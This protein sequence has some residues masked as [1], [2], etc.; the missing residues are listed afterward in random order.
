MALVPT[1]PQR[2]ASD[3]DGNNTRDAQ[4]GSGLP[5]SVP[6]VRSQEQSGKHILALSF[7]G[8]WPNADIIRLAAIIMGRPAV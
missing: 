4:M 3:P 2:L 1:P 7:S 5:L 8:F 6:Y